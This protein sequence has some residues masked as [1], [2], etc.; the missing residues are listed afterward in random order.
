MISA[1]IHT[2]NEEKNISR[3]LE[4]LKWVDEKVI[5]DMGSTDQTRSIA[6][7]YG[8]KIY[9]HAYTGFVEPARNF[10]IEKSTGEWILIVDADEEIPSALAR[11]LKEEVKN[12]RGDYYR[13][14]RK[15]IIFNKWIRR[16]GWWP[17]YQ[18]RFFRK[19]HVR[20][21]E[22]IH[23]IPMTKGTGIDIEAKEELSIIHY[24]YQT[25]DQY[26]SRMNRY[27]S[28]SAKELFVQNNKFEMKDLFEKPTREF[29]N[30][31]FTWEGYKD[32]IHGLV[33]SLLQS[34][35][36][37]VIFIKLW[38]L[39]G[40]SEQKINIDTIDNMMTDDFKEK[41]YWFIN[42]KSTASGN[43]LRKIYLKI[44]KKVYYG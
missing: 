31:F 2:F 25:I 20:W 5:V 19:D 21:T 4:S 26:L 30:R 40:F 15:N 23:G 22:K 28:I 29:I 32:G 44:Q 42:T 38:E 37:L 8:C 16:S 43:I 18:V 13:S 14:A 10:G 34:F 33:L 27:T 9:Q 36:E 7:K 6:K 11:Y 3:C 41:K 1:L 35:S 39:S 24:N 17:D 12:A